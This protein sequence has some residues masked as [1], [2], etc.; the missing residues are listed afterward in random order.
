MVE[1]RKGSKREGGK[2]RTRKVP[3]DAILVIISF[4]VSAITASIVFPGIPKWASWEGSP[5]M[6]M[7]LVNKIMRYLPGLPQWNDGWFFGCPAL[8]FYPPFSHI[9]MAFIGWILRIHVFQAYRVYTYLFFGMG[10]AFLYLLSRRLGLGKTGAL[11]SSIFF[12]F[13][14]NLYSFWNV[15][16]I[17]M[18]TGVF[19]FIGTFYFLL[20]AIETQSTVDML[21]GGALFAA[22]S[23]SHF[24]DA[25]ISVL[26]LLIFSVLMVIMKPELFIKIEP[27]AKLPEYTLRL[28]KA[29]AGIILVGFGLSA[30]WWIPFFI[31]GGYSQVTRGWQIGLLPA[32]APPKSELIL[33]HLKRIFGINYERNLW[34]PGTGQIALAFIGLPILVKDKK[35][36]YSKLSA[37]GFIISFIV[38]LFPILKV[39]FPL[40]NRFSPYFSLFSALIAGYLTQKVLSSYKKKFAILL[41]LILVSASF[42]AIREVFVNIAP[43]HKLIETEI[44]P[45][46]LWLRNNARKGERLATDMI[47]WI[48]RLDLYTDVGLSGGSLQVE[49]INDFAYTFWYYLLFLSDPSYLRYFSNQYNVRFFYNPRF[50]EGLVGVSDFLF[51]YEVENFNSSLVE[52]IGSDTIKVMVFG[53]FADYQ[54]T[55]A[56][57]SPTGAEDVLLVYGGEFV[58]V[59][60]LENLSKFDVLYLFGIRYLNENNYYDKLREYVRRG[61]SVILDTGDLPHGGASTGLEEPFPITDC[62]TRNSNFNLSLVGNWTSRPVYTSL[63]TKGEYGISYTINESLRG[64]AIPLIYDEDKAVLAAVMEYGDGKVL[65]TGLNLPY[66]AV[67]HLNREESLLIEEMIKAVS[68]KGPKSSATLN[69]D[70]LMPERLTI[71]VNGAEADDALF[72]KISY[73]KG[74]SAYLGDKR[75]KIFKA[76]PGMMLIFPETSGSFDIEVRF[77]KL[78]YVALSEGLTIMSLIISLPAAIYIEFRRRRVKE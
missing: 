44:P 16:A 27:G 40:P 75:L 45:D 46:M 25:F 73:Y 29:L 64:G 6:H 13:S 18:I 38:L 3:L 7:S 42:F 20:R 8:R 15:G 2:M 60:S 32:G 63:F 39:P 26:L 77:E 22:T 17:P 51:L 41:V 37:V 54:R 65:W 76:G 4:L 1:V 10:S 49:M 28:P 48:W 74:W 30:W 35:A 67:Y 70:Y 58:D 57:I 43:H 61:G 23:L 19:L 52:L 56:A 14:Y 9:A 24:H 59:Q 50:G 31:E 36:D 72:V 78:G 62:W 21:V 69:F 11:A 68:E 55:F 33:D 12:T 66:H 5:L 34:S 53:S 71:H 47:E